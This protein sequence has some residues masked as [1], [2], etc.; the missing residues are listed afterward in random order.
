M[1]IE[2]VTK[3]LL[4]LEQGDLNEQHLFADGMYCR[5]GVRLQ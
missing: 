2:E 1:D 3:E 4:Q 5:H